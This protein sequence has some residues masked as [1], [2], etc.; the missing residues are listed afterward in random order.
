MIDE[1]IAN[2]E[3]YKQ[4]VIQQKHVGERLDPALIATFYNLSHMQFSALKKL[5]CA[6][7]RGNKTVEQDYGDVTGALKRDL[8]LMNLELS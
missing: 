6:G 2:G 8:E 4:G 1:S 5:L 3:H 7:N